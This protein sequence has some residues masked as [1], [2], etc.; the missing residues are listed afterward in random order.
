MVIMR[1]VA[2]NLTS[3]LKMCTQAVVSLSFAIWKQGRGSWRWPSGAGG[4]LLPARR[5]LHQVAGR[6]SGPAPAGAA[7]RR[8]G[9]RGG[10]GSQRLGPV[11]TCAAPG[12][13]SPQPLQRPHPAGPCPPRLGPSSLEGGAVACLGCDDDFRW[14]GGRSWTSSKEALEFLLLKKHSVFFSFFGVV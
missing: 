1:H 9:G 10:G 12:R 5:W 8:C 11:A 13:D 7:G 4:W 14:V 6:R 2:E 3:R